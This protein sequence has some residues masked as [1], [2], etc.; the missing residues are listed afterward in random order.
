MSVLRVA[1]ESAEV[2]NGRCVPKVRS[3]F[4]PAALSYRERKAGSDSLGAGG[5]HSHLYRRRG[6]PDAS[7]YCHRLDRDVPP[8]IVECREFEGVAALT[9]DQMRE[10]APP[11]DSRPG[12]SDGSYR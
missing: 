2:K 10:I 7:V 5:R 4:M 11:I 1:G 12:I 9:L 3:T 6:R 8:D